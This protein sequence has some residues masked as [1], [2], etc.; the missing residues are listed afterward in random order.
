M[1]G[2][3]KKPPRE[4]DLTSRYLSG[5]M[6]EDRIEQS[7]RFS[8]RNKQAVQQKIERTAAMRTAEDEFTGDIHA[9]PVGQ[10]MQVYSLFSEVEHDGRTILCCLRNTMAKLGSPAIVVGDRVRSRTS[11]VTDDQGRAEAVIEQV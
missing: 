1:R 9:L 10:V 3:P 6:D 2:K 8:D 11:G 5:G 7:Q 4:K